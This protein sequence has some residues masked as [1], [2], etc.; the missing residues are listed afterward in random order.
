[1]Y[2]QVNASLSKSQVSKMKNA[3]KN[4]T[5]VSLR[6]SQDMLGTDSEQFPHSL[7]LTNR[8]VEKLR[9]QPTADIKIS[10]TQILKMS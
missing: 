9:R 6:L 2:N 3:L 4:R 7:M 8:Q 1:M 5:G 10:K